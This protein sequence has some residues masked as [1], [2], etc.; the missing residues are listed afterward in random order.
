MCSNR[1]DEHVS[2][3]RYVPKCWGLAACFASGGGYSF[4]EA[5]RQ[6]QQSL[7]GQAAPPPR[8]RRSAYRS[9][10][11]PF[12]AVGTA[13][14][15]GNQRRQFRRAARRLLKVTAACASRSLGAASLVRLH[16]SPAQLVQVAP[17][18]S[19]SPAL[20]CMRP[21]GE[22]AAQRRDQSRFPAS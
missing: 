9:A 17:S 8:L 6:R 3:T 18:Q 15:K 20:N 1:P 10:A 4:T 5:S 11:P 13:Q 14:P 21:D 12:S 22:I 16:V 2:K 7:C 19:D